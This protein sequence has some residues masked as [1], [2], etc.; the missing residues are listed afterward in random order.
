MVAIN[1]NVFCY[2]TK[3]RS[4]KWS[5]VKLKV[6]TQGNKYLRRLLHVAL[7]IVVSCQTHTLH[8][9]VSHT[10]RANQN[11]HMRVQTNFASLFIC[12]SCNTF[13]MRDNTMRSSFFFIEFICAVVCRS[14]VYYL[15]FIVQHIN[16]KIKISCSFF[17]SVLDESTT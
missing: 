11:S 16:I 8:I 6:H 14:G 4:P 10:A 3:L 7:P 13:I 2:W 17:F 12:H 1:Y 15:H 5:Q 9:C